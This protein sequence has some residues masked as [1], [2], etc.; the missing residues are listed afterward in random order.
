MDVL[1]YWSVYNYTLI[2]EMFF[3]LTHYCTIVGYCSNCNDL[4]TS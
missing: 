2:I 3:I 1:V 4:I